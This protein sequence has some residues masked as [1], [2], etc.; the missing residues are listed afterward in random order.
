MLVDPCS[1]Y[2][3]REFR[4]LLNCESLDLGETSR[5]PMS[6]SANGKG[7]EGH[8]HRMSTLGVVLA[9]LCT[10]IRLA[11]QTSPADAPLAEQ[12]EHLAAGQRWQEIV[13]QLEP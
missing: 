1:G 10:C 11:A 9:V 6:K 3:S 5:L 2:C 4:A 8:P 12:V 7:R 13:I